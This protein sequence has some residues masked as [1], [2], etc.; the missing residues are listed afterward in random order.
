MPKKQILFA[1]DV[2]DKLTMRRPE[3]EMQALMEAIPN[4]EPMSSSDEMLEL[5]EAVAAA[6]QSLPPKYRKAILYTTY[7]GLSLKEAGKKMGFSDVHVMRIRNAAYSKLQDALTMNITLRRRYEMA[8]TWEQSAAQWVGYVGSLSDKG[9]PKLDF[10][11]LRDRIDALIGTVFH[12]DKE[13]NSDAFTSIAVP[14]V[15][16]LRHMGEWDTGQM[17]MLLAAKQHDYGHKN[18]DRFGLKGIVVR[19][20]DKYERLANLEFTKQFF[21]EGEVVV[22]KVNETLV[23]TLVDIV[24]YCVIGLMVLD[25][26]FKLELGEGFAITSNNSGIR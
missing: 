26:T 20:N 1:S 23:D 2:F 4:T 24:G 10:G 18:I 7:E 6:V 22:P 19:L 8:K 25:D 5:R 9:K 15:H 12:N 3:S 11:L 14:V 21:E 13:P 16:Q 17:A